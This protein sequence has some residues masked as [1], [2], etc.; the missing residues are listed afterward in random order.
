MSV[1][2]TY[3]VVTRDTLVGGRPFRQVYPATRQYAAGVSWYESHEPL[4]A[5]SPRADYVKYGAAR[6]FA[7]GELKRV[8]EH[9]GVGLYAAPGAA[10]RPEVLYLPVRPGCWFH[11]YQLVGVGEVRG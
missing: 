8:G 3:S 11:A 10:G 7:P 4:P 2:G 5:P 1:A 6:L 9:R